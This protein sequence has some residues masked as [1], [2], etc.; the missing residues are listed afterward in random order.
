M[1]PREFAFMCILY[2]VLIINHQ[3]D[4]VESTSPNPNGSLPDNC[5]QADQ[6]KQRTFDDFYM[7]LEVCRP[8]ISI[9]CLTRPKNPCFKNQATLNAIAFVEG[10]VG[11]C[12]KKYF[13]LHQKEKVGNNHLFWLILQV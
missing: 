5:S 12:K 8:N 3:C 7:K 4:R 9:S 1:K 13:L 6:L 11:Q 10:H 2:M